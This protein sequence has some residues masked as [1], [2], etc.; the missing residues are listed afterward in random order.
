[1]KKAQR[2]LGHELGKGDSYRSGRVSVSC[3]LAIAS[4]KNDGE[5][6]AVFRRMLQ[7]MEWYASSEHG[8][9][10]TPIPVPEVED[11]EEE[12]DEQ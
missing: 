7:L 5:P 4:L 2:S 8:H 9:N 3:F 10:E 11:E 1:M 6:R 12:E